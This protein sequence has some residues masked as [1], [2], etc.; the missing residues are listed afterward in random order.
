MRCK[1]LEITG[2][3]SVS[4]VFSEGDDMDCFAMG[5]KGE[6]GSWMTLVP[7]GRRTLA[8]YDGFRSAL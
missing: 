7:A 1:N 2:Q 4:R 3:W 5:S 6:D 8:G